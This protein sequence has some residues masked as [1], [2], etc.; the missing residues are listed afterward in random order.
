VIKT[1]PKS[2]INWVDLRL[3]L[4]LRLKI[5]L[6]YILLAVLLAIGGALVISQLIVDSVQERFVNQLLETGRLAA[7]RVVEVEQE[8]LATL[9]IV[10]HTDGVARALLDGDTEAAR[11]LV[12]PVAINDRTDV[13]ELLD[14]DGAAF[15]SLYRQRG[16]SATDYA[17][18]QGADLYLTWP[19]VNRVLRGEEDEAGDKF[20][21]LVPDAPGGATFYVAGPIFYEDEL[22]GAILVGSYL[23]QVVA[24]LRSSSGAHHVTIY[25]SDGQPLMTTIPAESGAVTTITPDWY[26]TVLHR[27]GR[28]LV[29]TAGM[30]DQ[31]YSQAFLPFEAR[32]GND[33]AVLS[34]ALS[35]GYLV[36]TSP[37]SRL[38][39]TL[40]TVAT[41]LGVIA[42]GTAVARQIARPVLAIARASRHVAQGDLSQEVQVNTRDEVGEL[43]QAFNEMVV[44][45][46]LAEA[47]KDI[48]GRAVSPEVSAALIDAV[49]SGQITLGGE[50]RQ[51]T[52]LFSDI[53]GFTSLSEQRTA[54][55]VMGMLN[56]FF[57]AIYPAID[58]YGGVINKFGGDSTMA[59]FGAPIPQDDHARR[60][61]FTGLAMCRAVAELNARRVDRGQVP[62]R[63]GVGINT[64]EVVVGTLGAAE[65]LEYTAIGDPVNV[66]SRIEGLTRR[67]EAHDV[68][69]SQATLDAIGSDHGFVIEDLGG[70]AVKG[71]TSLVH[72]YSVRGK[73]TDA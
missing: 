39:L 7:N 72:I 58:E 65:R 15:L 51:V 57:G 22:A 30:S 27:Q 1:L 43:A 10:A 46:R 38:S 63:I 35:Q 16:G 42:I 53:K 71:K 54:S 41:L 2:L 47:V 26:T 23:D 55:Q 14:R 28:T 13:I 20:A 11:E 18:V 9:R 67:L 36:R 40:I 66:A 56:E 33:L 48:F 3:R 34:T 60:A 29:N 8:S 44:Q 69:I 52:I 37:V 62:I 61:V 50:T 45:L 12:Y 73:A 24:D 6:P 64:G 4:G 68:L 31:P 5:T 25:T 49:S 19:F 21:G 70:F 17:A 32:H 59:L